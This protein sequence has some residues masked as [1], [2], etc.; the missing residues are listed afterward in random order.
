M[1]MADAE[2]GRGVA[3]EFVWAPAELPL[4]SE[5]LNNT[6]LTLLFNCVEQNAFQFRG[7]TSAEVII[8]SAL[9]RVYPGR[10]MIKLDTN[11]TSACKTRRKGIWQ[12]RRC[13][14]PK[15]V[16]GQLGDGNVARLI[17]GPIET[18]ESST[19]AWSSLR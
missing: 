18:G 19:A 9:D 2:F 11:T 13:N 6:S 15:C 16:A 3:T 4:S 12:Q 1:T 14:C 5:E 8:G 7:Q 10:F 17:I